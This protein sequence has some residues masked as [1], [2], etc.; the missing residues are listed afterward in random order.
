MD[1]Y[2]A[3]S[4][5]GYTSYSILTRE[6]KKRMNCRRPHQQAAAAVRIA[7]LARGLGPGARRKRDE[8]AAGRICRRGGRRTRRRLTGKGDVERTAGGRAERRR[9][10]TQRNATQRR[11]IN[12][13]E[14]KGDD[15][16]GNSTGDSTS[17]N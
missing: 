13:K 5:R 4:N 6:K 8:P 3:R 14:R 9:N 11:D 10:A 1:V 12:E 7:A 2:L 17:T 16:K 15:E